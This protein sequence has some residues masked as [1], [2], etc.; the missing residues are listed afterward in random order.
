MEDI[1]TDAAAFSF[2][3]NAS[4]ESVT[5]EDDA[6]S[7]GD[8]ELDNMV[9]ENLRKLYQ[10]AHE[11]GKD[12]LQIRLECRPKSA[13][14]YHLFV[15]PFLSRGNLK[16]DPGFQEKYEDLLYL[17]SALPREALPIYQDLMSDMQRRGFAES[18]VICQVEVKCDELFWVKD[19]STG[20]VVQGSED[21][22]FREVS[23]LV[24]MEMVVTTVLKKNSFIPFEMIPG[25]WQI[26]DIDDHLDGNMMV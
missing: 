2:E 19:L 7:I 4:D 17:T 1:V 23:H 22:E 26:T 15:F 18:T 14:M 11:F 12:Q 13:K 10:A 24:R 8:N 21:E 6:S 9:Q 5:G 25:Q 3:T 20:R 16:R